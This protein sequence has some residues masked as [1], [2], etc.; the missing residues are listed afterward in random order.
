MA[1]YRRSFNC[2]G[3]KS[4]A[5][6]DVKNKTITIKCRHCKKIEI[7]TE[8]TFFTPLANFTF[9]DEAMGEC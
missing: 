5:E 8:D 3:C 6:I 2:K 4:G 7:K 9:R 1:K